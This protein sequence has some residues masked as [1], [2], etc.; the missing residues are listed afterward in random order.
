MDKINQTPLNMERDL[1]RELGKKIPFGI[2][3]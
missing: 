3:G 2:K 1:S